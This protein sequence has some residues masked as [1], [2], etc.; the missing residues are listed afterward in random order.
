MCAA[1]AQLFCGETVVKPLFDGTQEA[2]GIS[3]VD[4]S[5][6]VGERQMNHITGSESQR[7]VA[8][9]AWEHPLDHCSGPENRGFGG[10]E[11]GGIKQRAAAA[12][13]GDREGT[14]G[15]VTWADLSTA[16]M[17]AAVEIAVTSRGSVMCCASRM[18]G[19]ISPLGPLKGRWGM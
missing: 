11:D 1:S 16:D 8:I 14:S 10:I 15:Q 19:T 17:S 18:T 3:V 4:R 9:P 13:V 2:S 7:S 6:V 12:G 5:V